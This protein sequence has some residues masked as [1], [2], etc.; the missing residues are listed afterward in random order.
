MQRAVKGK[1]P[2]MQ[3]ELSA[4]DLLYYYFTI[5]EVTYEIHENRPDPDE[6]EVTKIFFGGLSSAQVNKSEV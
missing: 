4:S 5:S 2:S 3:A 1:Y 6:L